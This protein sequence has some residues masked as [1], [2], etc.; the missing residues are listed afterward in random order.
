MCLYC[1]M[2]G[3]LQQPPVI[4]RD[5]AVGGGG[6]QNEQLKKN[7]ISALNKL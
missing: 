5:V 7:S 4:F 2:Y 1:Y 3:K 6:R